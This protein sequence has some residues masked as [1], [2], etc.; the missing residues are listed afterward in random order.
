MA[1]HLYNR[2]MPTY[3]SGSGDDGRTSLLGDQRVPKY[4]PRPEAY[5]TIDEASAALGWA[6]SLALDEDSRRVT[7]QVQRDLY[8]VM[9]EVAATD[10]NAE[11]FRIIDSER[12]AWLESQVTRIGER[13]A[14][15][16]EFVIAGDSRSGA[17]YDMARTAVRRAERR[18]AKLV[19]E[20]DLENKDLL[21]YLNRLSS[22]CFVLSL[23]ANVQEGI[24]RPSLASGQ[25][26]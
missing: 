9:S 12:V 2:R 1:K 4:D 15:P 7:V 24:D 25:D 16:K 10:E 22:L 6:R 19:L 8:H 18:V 11:K 23:W 17:A 21:R 14:L 26:S 3:F 13:V 5:G 20:G